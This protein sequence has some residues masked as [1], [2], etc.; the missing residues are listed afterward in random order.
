MLSRMRLPLALV[1]IPLLLYGGLKGF[2]HYRTTDG[3]DDLKSRIAPYATLQHGG[4]GSSLWNGRVTVGQVTLQ[5][6]GFTDV[7]RIDEVA[8]E[9]GS[10]PAL[11]GS[12][13]G[14]DGP[15]EKLRVE[16]RGLAFDMDGPMM[17]ALDRLLAQAASSGAT[18]VMTHCGGIAIMG[19]RQYRKLGY[20]RLVNDVSFGWVVDRRAQRVRVEFDG[21][22]RDMGSFSGA[23]EMAGLPAGGKTAGEAKPRLAR[24]R[25]NYRDQ[26]YVQRAQRYCTEASGL[27]AEQYIDAEVE[28]LSATFYQT[29]GEGL[30]PGLRAAYRD[31]LVNPGELRFEMQPPEDFDMRMLALL[32]PGDILGQ[33]N[34]TLVVNGDAVTDLSFDSNARPTVVRPAADTDTPIEELP[35]QLAARAE[36]AP[37]TGTSDAADGYRAV[38][39]TELARH[40]GRKVRV[41]VI[42]AATREGVLAGVQPLEIVIERRYRGGAMSV[43]VPT[44]RIA[45][46]DALF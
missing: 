30:G 1:V 17:A 39:V 43:R 44:N 37:R 14:E 33:L 8:I 26:S 40:I 42:G 15:P 19:P 11:L 45:R 36:P 29:W 28:H 10:L 41:H 12:T 4:I 23:M 13:W 18:P 38:P 25:L 46:V 24:L 32:T 22:T 5:P 9:A 31:F 21:L 7:I 16:V 20:E 6:T 2:V 34:V 27:S 35:P 3:L